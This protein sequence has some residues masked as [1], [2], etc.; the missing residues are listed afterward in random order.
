MRLS[1]GSLT[2]YLTGWY[3]WWMAQPAT[4]AEDA[5]AQLRDPLRLGERKTHNELE[6]ARESLMS[7]AAQ[8]SLSVSARAGF[9]GHGRG[10]V[11]GEFASRADLSAAE[12]AEL[13]LDPFPHVRSRLAQSASVLVAEVVEVL[14][15]DPDLYV[16]AKLA[17]RSGLTA[18]Q[19]N[20]LFDRYWSLSLRNGSHLDDPEVA[21]VASLVWGHPKVTAER[22]ERHAEHPDIAPN[23]ATTGHEKYRIPDGIRA[24]LA[25]EDCPEALLRQY[26]TSA[27]PVE[28]RWVASEARG[29]TEDLRALLSDDSDSEVALAY[30]HRMV[31]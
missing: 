3:P 20:A 28:R 2:I 5:L 4:L 10:D 30:A 18:E 25:R 7:E 29:L 31:P 6:A 8:P 24:V 15:S 27:N 12:Q 17:G 11:R 26:A 14:A 21:E 19:V 23:G 1:S 16:V 22:L 9:L 13:A